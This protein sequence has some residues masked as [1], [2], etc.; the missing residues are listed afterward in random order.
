MLKPFMIY[1]VLRC[2]TL[3]VLETGEKKGEILE[4]YKK[5]QDGEKADYFSLTDTGRA[6]I[7]NIGK[8]YVCARY[9]DS[10]LKFEH[11]RVEVQEIKPEEY[12]RITNALND[13]VRI[14][15]ISDKYDELFPM[16]TGKYPKIEGA[17]P[18]K[19]P[20]SKKKKKMF[21]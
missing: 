10:E 17:K 11:C 19:A 1:L 9:G 2:C 18:K 4:I 21:D 16:A 7:D 12:N 20:P 13:N 5:V 6:M 14:Q 15:D 8:V 3:F